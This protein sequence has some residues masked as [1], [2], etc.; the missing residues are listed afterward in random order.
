MNELG[1]AS[2]HLGNGYFNTLVKVI[3]GGV[4][5]HG[6]NRMRFNIAGEDYFYIYV[7]DLALW[8]FKNSL[9]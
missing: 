2:Y 8:W 9:D 6:T 4:L 7:E 5:Q 1:A 3:G